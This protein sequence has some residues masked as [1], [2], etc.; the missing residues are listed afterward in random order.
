MNDGYHVSLH[1]VF[2][3]EPAIVSATTSLR[4]VG[5][6]EIIFIFAGTIIFVLLEQFL[7]LLEPVLFFATRG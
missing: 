2:L 5:T 6:D 3:L 7:S 1:R 4:R